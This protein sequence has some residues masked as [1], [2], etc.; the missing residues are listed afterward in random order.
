MKMNAYGYTKDVVVK[1]AKSPCLMVMSISDAAPDVFQ[2]PVMLHIV[3]GEVWVTDYDTFMDAGF[4]AEHSIIP[5]GQNA[6]WG[7]S[8]AVR[9]AW[10]VYD[11]IDEFGEPGSVLERI[12]WR[13]MFSALYKFATGNE[14]IF[15]EVA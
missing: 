10:I 7:S 1:D 12:E 3:A 2:T 6:G 14:I 8:D 4:A 9:N 5:I 15:K 13:E 11:G